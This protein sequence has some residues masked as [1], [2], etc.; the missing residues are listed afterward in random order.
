MIRALPWIFFGL[1][2]LVVLYLSVLLLNG[3]AALNDARS[4]V[5][6]LRERSNIALSIVRKDWIG[7]D[8][9]SVNELSR[10]FGRQGVI[11]G[12]EDGVFEIGDF[13]FETRD[14]LIMEVHYID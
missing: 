14:G 5:E 4:E 8:A 3:G 11:V 13:I 10:E 7:K 9:T 6:R 12:V 2:L 1:A